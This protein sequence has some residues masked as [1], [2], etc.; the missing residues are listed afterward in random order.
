MSKSAS[1]WKRKRQYWVRQRALGANAARA[2]WHF[3]SVRTWDVGS[4][5]YTVVTLIYDPGWT[6]HHDM[7][8]A[9]VKEKA[10]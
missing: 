3:A 1:H 6:V 10:L 4:S 2:P 7:D 8:L 5:D 9:A